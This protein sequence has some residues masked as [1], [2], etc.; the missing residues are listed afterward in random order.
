[1]QRQAAEGDVALN[2]LEVLQKDTDPI[3]L[4]AACEFARDLMECDEIQESKETF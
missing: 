3:V 1:M 2:I 4:T